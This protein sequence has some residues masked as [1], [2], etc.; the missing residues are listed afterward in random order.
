[1]RRTILP[2]IA[3]LMLT[4][5]PVFA[6]AHL[7]ASD[8]S[9]GAVLVQPP[10]RLWLRFNQIVRLP[11][12]GLELTCPDGHTR[13]LGPLTRDPG[14]LRGVLS[15]LPPGLGPGPYLVRW[16]ALSPN[17]HRTHGDF[18]FTVRP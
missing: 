1:M 16:R 13:R 18:G 10:R 8:P 14:D 6:H 5:G 2:S 17:A 11:G 7:R 12:T 15:P 3:L 9:A 4:A